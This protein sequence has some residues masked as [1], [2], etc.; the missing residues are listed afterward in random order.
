MLLT[1]LY[2]FQFIKYLFVDINWTIFAAIVRYIGGVEFADGCWLGLELKT[3]AGKNDGSVQGKQYFTCK[4]AHGVMVRPSRVSVKGING[5]KLLGDQHHL[6][7][8]SRHETS[9]SNPMLDSSK[10]SD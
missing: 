3:A 9:D 1:T 7:N 5:T 2:I 10:A 4:P 8:T 6:L